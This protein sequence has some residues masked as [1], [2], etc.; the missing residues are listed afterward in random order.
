ML[1]IYLEIFLEFRNESVIM[2]HSIVLFFI[3][4]TLYTFYF[5]SAL[6]MTFSSV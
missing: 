3:P 1:I 6:A 2:F 4:C 5:F